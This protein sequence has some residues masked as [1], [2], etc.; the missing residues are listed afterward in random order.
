VVVDKG[1]R[2]ELE[3][4]SGFE[5]TDLEQV[6]RDH[7]IDAVTVVGLATDYCVKHTAR[8]ALAAGF[9]V[10]VDREGVRGIDVEPG[11]SEQAL[12]ELSQGGATVR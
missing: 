10:T 1:H 5:E 8:D 2:P 11:D 12:R 9:D 4:Y 7:G 6:L 3:G